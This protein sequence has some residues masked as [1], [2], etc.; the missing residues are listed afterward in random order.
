MKKTDHGDSPEAIRR[1]WGVT[2]IV[3]AAALF[4]AATSDVV[5]EATSPSAFSWHVVVRK[6]YS[7][8]AF[9]LIGF[10]ADN[11]LGPS[12]RAYARGAFLV[13]A[14][15][16]AIEIAQAA[17]G[18]HEGLVWNAIDVLCGA[19]GGS[20]GVFVERIRRSRRKA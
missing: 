16:T 17:L 2:A 1:V 13:A 3:I 18:S 6:A 9:A 20:L 4:W 14:Y 19:V 7:I 12:A 15:S 5:Y 8:V 10:T 11:A